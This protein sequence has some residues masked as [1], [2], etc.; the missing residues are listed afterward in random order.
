LKLAELR[1]RLTLAFRSRLRRSSITTR[2]ALLLGAFTIVILWAAT[3]A[4]YWA[5]VLSLEHD[6]QRFVAEKTHVLRTMLDERP[7]DQALLREEVDW[8]TRVLGYGHYFVQILDPAG[9]VVTQTPGLDRSG[10]EL[11]AFPP[12]V[13]STVTAP[14]TVWTRAAGGRR[15][16]LSSAFAR[17]ADPPASRRIVRIAL[18]VSH[19]D[20]IL[21]D[22]RRIAALVLLGGVVLAGALGA[23]AARKGLQPLS[24]IARTVE[25]TT[26]LR[27]HQRLDPA[28]WPKELTSLAQA[29]NRMLGSLERAFIRLSSYAAELAHE[30]RTPLSNL[31]GETEVTLARPRS[32]EQ[33]RLTLHSNLEEYQ[34]LARMIDNLLFLARAEQPDSHLE[35][36]V[37]DAVEALREVADFY[38]A[39]A[40]EAGVRLDCEGG[41]S[42][43]ADRDL[44]RRAVSN[45]LANAL[46]HTRA[47]GQVRIRAVQ[48]PDGALEVQVADMGSGIPAEEQAHVFDR[49]FRG[50]ENRRQAEGAGLGLAIVKSIMEAH[51]GSVRLESELDRGTTVILAFP[52]PTSRSPS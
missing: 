38:S 36:R 2:L 20:R 10:I 41:G 21:A 16:L 17:A 12:P 37:F 50:A 6:D 27:L 34:R 25:E 15:Y 13:A 23:A 22:F 19:E 14:S 18:D 28:A 47:G 24:A 40:E 46:R 26:A 32:A 43:V 3:A 45:V 9:D 1:R 7:D 29:F 49:F 44:F 42:T 11:K 51:G 35:R 5:V 33:Y 39:A 30:L 52:P 8:E 48:G 31:M 4:L